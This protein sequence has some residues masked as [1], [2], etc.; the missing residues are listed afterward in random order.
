MVVVNNKYPSVLFLFQVVI[1][2]SEGAGIKE[3]IALFITDE[4]IMNII[5][6]IIFYCVLA[7]YILWLFSALSQGLINKSILSI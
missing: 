1:L 5:S 3:F 6:K 7:L 2:F 4:N